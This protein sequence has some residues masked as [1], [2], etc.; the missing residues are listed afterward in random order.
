MSYL[1]V[2]AL[3]LTHGPCH[4]VCCRK[5]SRIGLNRWLR[6]AMDKLQQPRKDNTWHHKIIFLTQNR[7]TSFYCSSLYCSLMIL[8][9]FKLIDVLWQPCLVQVYQRHFSNS[10]CLLRV[11]VARFGNFYSIL[12]IFIIIFVRVV[13]DLCVTFV[14][15]SRCHECAHVRWQT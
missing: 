6:P 13:S 10:I 12:N 8:P 11:S 9:F 7:L 5:I 3:I 1:P 2:V 15:V 14:V 4:K